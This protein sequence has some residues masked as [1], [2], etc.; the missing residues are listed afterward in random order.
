MQ[1]RHADNSWHEGNCDGLLAEAY[2]ANKG[3]KDTDG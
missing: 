2:C 3:S 1:D